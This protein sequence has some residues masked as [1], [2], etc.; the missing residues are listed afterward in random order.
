MFEILSFSRSVPVQTFAR[1]IFGEW[2]CRVCGCARIFVGALDAINVNRWRTEIHIDFVCAPLT[3][4]W[5]LWIYDGTLVPHTLSLSSTATR[6]AASRRRHVLWPEHLFCN[7]IFMFFTRIV[8]VNRWNAI[9]T[10]HI[11]ISYFRCDFLA[12]FS[13]FVYYRLRRF[14]MNFRMR[15]FRSGLAFTYFRNARN[16]ARKNGIW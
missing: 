10:G 2:L 11:S 1:P 12:Y 7:T 6:S 14:N 15:I 13:V 16:N 9:R 4:W 3:R 8:R 5:C